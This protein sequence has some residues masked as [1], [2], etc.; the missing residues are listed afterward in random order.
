MDATPFTK[1][2][3]YE[4]THG[5]VKHYYGFKYALGGIVVMKGAD[6]ERIN[7][8]PCYWGWGMEDNV[9]QTRCEKIGLTIDRSH[10]FPIGNPN[11]LQLFDG[12]SRIIN[13]K[14]PWRA[15]HDNGI[16]GIRTIHKLNY[17]ID[18]HNLIT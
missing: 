13:R 9:L 15:Q 18:F 1:I 12:V 10:F 5:V 8:Y 16:D 3:D 11:I 6:F 14:D 7:G 17:K 4:T 2:F